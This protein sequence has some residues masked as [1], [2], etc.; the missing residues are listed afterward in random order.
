METKNAISMEA[1]AVE[2]SAGQAY[3]RTGAPTA[4][5]Y[6][7]S[8]T[9]GGFLNDTNGTPWVLLALP[10]VTA[11]GSYTGFTDYND[12]AVPTPK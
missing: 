12:G 4:A 7:Y 9:H 5:W 6:D 8:M 3:L 11:A 1:D 10:T 2:V